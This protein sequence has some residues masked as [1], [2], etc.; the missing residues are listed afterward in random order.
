MKMMQDQV[1]E[2]VEING[3]LN[4][5]CLAL[6]V[7][8][9]FI[10][11][12]EHAIEAIYTFPLPHDAVLLDLTVKLNDKILRG[13]VIAKK[14]AVSR[15]EDAIT[16]GD[17][18]IMLERADN[19]L[20][21][22]NVGN[23]LA[24]ERAQICYRFSQL[25]YWQQDALRISIPTTMAPRY[26][27]PIEAGFEPHQVTGHSITAEYPFKLSM[28]I[29]E[30]LANSLIECPSHAISI[31]HKNQTAN[32]TLSNKH[33]WLDRDFILNITA[34]N[35]EKNIGQFALDGDQY[36][37]LLSIVPD[38][39]GEQ[40]QSVC[41]K[42]VVDCSGSM[43]GESIE[44]AKIGILRILDHLRETDTFNI[45]RFGNT[46]H[47]IFPTCVT[48]TKKAIRQARKTIE[49]LAADL[50]GTEMEDAL[51]FAYALQDEGDRPTNI[52]LITDGEVYQYQ[53][54]IKKA[55]LSNHRIF[56][57]GVGSNVSEY[58]VREV[59]LQTGGAT[60]LV[61][62]NEN[63]AATIYR[64]FT[65]MYQ[66]RALSAKILWPTQPNWQTPS[67]IESVYAGDTLHLFAQFK[68]A[69]LGDATLKLMMEDGQT[70]EQ[71]LHIQSKSHIQDL[72]RIAAAQRITKMDSESEGL[73]TSLAVEYQ[74]ISE[75][76]NYLIVEERASKAENLD[77]PELVQVPHMMAAGHAG[78][79]KVTRRVPLF[80][81]KFSK[82]VRPERLS[83]SMVEDYDFPAFLRK[84]IDTKDDSDK[85]VKNLI[86]VIRL[87]IA[88]PDWFDAY[89]KHVTEILPD[90]LKETLDLL[91]KD[92]GWDVKELAAA[93][94]MVIIKKLSIE[95]PR[96]DLRVLL[97]T[98]K[99]EN[100]SQE[101]IEYF[102]D[103]IKLNK[104]GIYWMNLIDGFIASC[105]S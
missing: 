90:E 35:I 65:R 30:P 74:L 84:S 49:N 27:N 89:Q 18:A 17:S 57:V 14:Q 99:T 23:L 3:R 40:V 36:V 76:T 68:D 45:V 75:Y 67:T 69:P 105:K 81:T 33:A 10:N 85:P 101:I 91:V 96:H 66:P 58:V 77:L 70:I 24:G 87:V 103:G 47:A 12:S 19:D 88:D 25:L 79:G 46:A 59:A 52:L 42:V 15:Y 61:S 92:H 34:H 39:P 9:N 43:E 71:K 80:T 86:E 54:L 21:T 53:R 62:P 78:F 97:F 20:C 6:E 104:V 93:L 60:E 11:T 48:A 72:S 8:Q 73:A 29:T 44:Q 1:L 31:S 41:V 7:T 16:D 56:S 83:S 5:L 37:G 28:Q 102:M 98:L 95:I 4:G 38:I 2:S 26:G 82:R 51:D 94:L 100:P 64:Q 55:K 13:N 63:M 32:I 22:I 50:G